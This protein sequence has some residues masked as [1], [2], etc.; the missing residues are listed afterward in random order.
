MN[1]IDVKQRVQQNE[2][3]V[4]ELA[5]SMRKMVDYVER[6]VQMVENLTQHVEDLRERVEEIERALSK[7]SEQ[8]ALPASPPLRRI[9]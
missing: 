4:V 6:A 8:V 9:Q 1:D 2:E 3:D 5:I 7:K